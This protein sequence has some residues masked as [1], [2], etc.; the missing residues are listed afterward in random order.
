MPLCH[1]GLL[2][3]PVRNVSVGIEADKV[4]REVAFETVLGGDIQH[5]GDFAQDWFAAV[6]P[7]VAFNG[8]HPVGL[9]DYEVNPG[10][11]LRPL[12]TKLDNGLAVRGI[13]NGTEEFVEPFLPFLS[14]L[15]SSL[16]VVSF[17]VLLQIVCLDVAGFAPLRSA[18]V[19][20]IVVVD[21]LVVPPSRPGL[22][23]FTAARDIALVRPL[24]RMGPHVFHQVLL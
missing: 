7:L 5:S 24:T 6:L 13:T 19:R 15:M 18:P 16:S 10:K 21:H 4:E 12:P 2:S 17:D 1:L 14:S 8:D 11:L 20:A 9:I 22:E 3:P 23:S